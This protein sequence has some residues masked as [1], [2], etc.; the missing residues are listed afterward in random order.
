MNR[1][2]SD[3][4]S[5]V[6]ISQIAEECG[7]SHMTVSRALRKSNKVAEKTRRKIQNAAKRLGYRLNVRMGRPR[8]YP[9]RGG[10]V[11]VVMGASFAPGNMFCMNLLIV[12]EQG[13]ARLGQDCVIRTC[14][15]EYGSFLSLCESLRASAATGTIVIGAFLLEQTETILDISPGALFLDYMGDPKLTKPHESIG[16]DNTEAARMGVRHLVEIGRK[17]I[18]LL[19]GPEEHYF[20]RDIV[21]GYRD[22]LYHNGI[23]CEKSLILE[24]DFTAD[25]AA[26]AVTEAV[27]KGLEFD[28]IFTNDEM[29]VGVIRALHDLGKNVPADVAVGGC[30]GLPVG[31]HLIP[32]L[33]TVVMDYNKMGQLAVDRITE[34]S[35]K[36]EPEYHIRLL[37]NL[38]VRESTAKE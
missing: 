5:H 2:H 31:K 29:A 14:D 22:I 9:K 27:E 25:G 33:T 34:K 30:D 1:T 16:F 35:G 26:L 37:P 21:Q 32:S 38:Q 28:A 7:V 3:K 18:A 10:S 23:P 24:A 11:D 19:R 13:L 15:G 12:I 20:S 8:S 36:T 4:V 17:R 6:S